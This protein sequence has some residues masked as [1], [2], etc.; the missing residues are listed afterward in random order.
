MNNNILVY[1]CH[2]TDK[3]KITT[4][5]LGVTKIS[6]VKIPEHISIRILQKKK[7][8]DGF[9]YPISQDFVTF[10]SLDKKLYKL[11]YDL[12]FPKIN[13][14]LAL[15]H[16]ESVNEVIRQM[17]IAIIKYKV[18]EKKNFDPWYYADTHG[19]LCLRP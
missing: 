13:L 17:A 16:V 6:I 4:N 15:T 10:P 3:R 19:Y 1:Y 8:Y 12:L 2:N 14:A 5:K 11:T 7:D 18:I 9:I